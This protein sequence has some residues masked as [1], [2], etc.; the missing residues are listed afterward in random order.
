[1]EVARQGSDEA[2]IGVEQV[3]ATQDAL[4]GIGVAVERIHQM[5]E[6]MAAA[7]EQQAHVAEDISR[8][9]TTIAQV[10]EQNVDIAASSATLGRDLEHTAHEM[11]ALVDRF[12]R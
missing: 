5:T 11:Y 7:S 10:S 8:Q 2:H 12:N 3:I 4:E 6:Q 9:I 1:M